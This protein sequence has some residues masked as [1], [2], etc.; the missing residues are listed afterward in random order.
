M[1]NFAGEAEAAEASSMFLDG[2][3]VLLSGVAGLA[4]GAMENKL[5]VLLLSAEGVATAGPPNE[6]AG[7]LGVDADSDAE[8][9]SEITSWT[10]L[11]TS[12]EVFLGVAAGSLDLF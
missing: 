5:L 8:A 4:V 7:A 12:A 11:V 1:P 3:N 2:V 9:L 6:N 10:S